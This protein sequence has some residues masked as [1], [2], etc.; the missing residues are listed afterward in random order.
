MATSITP[1][2]LTLTVKEEININ[3]SENGS[4]NQKAISNIT[5]IFKRIVSCPASLDTT[6]LK[7]ASAVNVGPNDLDV[8]DCKYLRVTNKDSA[9]AVKVAYVTTNTNFQ[10]NLAAGE[11]HIFGAP[12]ALAFGD[13]D[14]D[15]Q[16]PTLENLVQV[17]I[18]PA[19]NIV[20]VEV[21][22]ASV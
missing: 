4:L 9:N 17:E 20:D 11:S 6:I 13:D 14:T 15:P 16:F 10:V 18:N 22:A 19:G 12:T 8:D 1:A 21:F 2:T 3:G 7:F 5:Q